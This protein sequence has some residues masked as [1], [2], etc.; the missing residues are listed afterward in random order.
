MTLEDSICGDIKKYG[1]GTQVAQSVGLLLV[2]QV[3]GLL[4]F[5]LMW[6]SLLSGESTSPSALPPIH[7]LSLKLINKQTY[8]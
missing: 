4:E 7:V 2:T 6:D 5:S 8:K 1:W 3:I